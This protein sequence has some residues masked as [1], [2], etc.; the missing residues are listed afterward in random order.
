MARGLNIQRVINVTLTIAALAAGY[1]NFGVSMAISSEEVIDT[2]ERIRP[3]TSSEEVV[4]DFGTSSPTA[5]A[6]ILYFSQDPQPSIF[7]V[8][9]WAQFATPGA[10]RGKILTGLELLLSR[11]TTVT[12]GSF[13]ISIDG[14]PLVVTAVNLSTATNLNGVASLIQAAIRAKGGAAGVTAATVQ[15]DGSRFTVRSGT[16]GVTS[17]VSYGAAHAAGTDLSGI[18]GF[19]TDAANVPVNGIAAESYLNAVSIL[20]DK[21]SD[22]Y[23]CAAA[24]ETQPSV[25]DHLAVA[26]YIE[27]MTMRRLYGVTTQDTAV[28]DAT[29]GDDFA[30]QAKLLGLERTFS[31][32]SSWS[33][34][35]IFSFMARAATVIFEGSNTTITLKFKRLPGIVA[36]SLSESQVQALTNKNCNVFVNYAIGSGNNAIAIVQEGVMANG[37]YFDEVQGTDW[38]VNKVQTDLFNLFYQSTT[39]IPQTDEGMIIIVN[40]INSSFSQSVTNGLVAPGQWNADGFGALRRGAT[41]TRG[42]YVYCPP[43]ASQQQADRERRISP[44]IQAAAKL[45]GAVHKTNLAITVNR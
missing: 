32:F 7:Y 39:K 18:L 31:I 41:L 27:S 42:F 8:G 12:D 25:T 19:R 36:E 14:A 6:A 3:Y 20:A 16:T 13:L 43:V 37:Y 9:R 24:T 26:S 33:P 22:W 5:Q 17:T 11:Y 34:L 2:V 44:P 35:A 10:L 29:R 4:A 21:S 15:W 45:A 28:L 38:L 30:S 40:Q 23:M 1:R